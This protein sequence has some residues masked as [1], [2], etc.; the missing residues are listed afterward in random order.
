[1]PRGRAAESVGDA[2]R[3]ERSAVAE[4]KTRSLSSYSGP[5]P[6]RSRACVARCR[7]R[8]STVVPSMAMVRRLRWIFGPA[9]QVVPLALSRV[10]TTATCPRE[11]SMSHQRSPRSS[12][13]RM[14]VVT[15][16]LSPPSPRTRP[17]LS[18]SLYEIRSWL[19]VSDCRGG[20]RCAAPRTGAGRPR[21]AF[22][23]RAGRRRRAGR[24]RH[25]APGDTPVS[26]RTATRVAAST[27]GLPWVSGCGTGPGPRTRACRALR[28]PP[29]RSGGRPRASCRRPAS[30]R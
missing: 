2:V 5:S 14:P 13:R 22:R 4:A 17:L 12:A 8:T 25:S 29:P 27:T 28:A 19:R 23:L 20:P 3:V 11:R 1:M 30:G 16:R 9:K 26:A 24:A 18:R 15:F 21:S 10:R 6:R 7:L